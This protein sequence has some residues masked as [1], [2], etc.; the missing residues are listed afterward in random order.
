M[1][2]LN[3][4]YSVIE[5]PLKM[6]RKYGIRSTVLI[7]IEAIQR[8]LLRRIQFKCRALRNGYLNKFKDFHLVLFHKRGEMDGTDFFNISVIN[9]PNKTNNSSYLQHAAVVTT[10]YQKSSYAISATPKF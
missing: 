9:T 8:T 10:S 5:K 3:H 4:M 7:S 2:S 6:P 1:P